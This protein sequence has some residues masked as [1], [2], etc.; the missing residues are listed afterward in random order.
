M[1]SWILT[2][3]YRLEL[4]EMPKPN[5]GPHEALVRMRHIGLC[6]SDLEIYRGHRDP[7]FLTTPVRAGHEASGVVE[8]VGSE[9]QGLKP[10]D[11][12]VARGIWGCFSEYIAGPMVSP[13]SPRAMPTL[14]L[15]KLPGDFPEEYGPFIEVL[16]K[17]VRTGERIGVTSG[18]DV[19]I[20]GQG[21]CGLLLTQV[22]RMQNPHRLVVLDLHEHKLDLARRYGATHTLDASAGALSDLVRSVLPDGADIVIVAHLAGSGVPEAIEL[23]KWNGQLIL[24]GCLGKTEVDFYRL[25]ARGGDIL[26]T[27]MR[28]LEEDIRYCRKAV[29][30]VADGV[31]DLSRLITHRFDLD[32]VPEAFAAKD[33]GGPG[34]VAVMVDSAD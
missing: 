31:I 20:V 15:V 16:P 3:P 27:R 24:W 28:N 11:R 18:S 23:L 32:H 21:V 26:G 5:P 2:E 34:M 14:Q 9:V 25:H 17:I 29:E 4:V 13:P 22:V 30:Y 1:K 8:A 10:G 12:V 19:V 33:E 6:G 7:E